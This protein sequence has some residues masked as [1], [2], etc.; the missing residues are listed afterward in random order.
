M[1]CEFVQPLEVIGLGGV[2]GPGFAS[3]I[4]GGREHF[5][6]FFERAFCFPEFD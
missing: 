2:G 4:G 5:V 3:L 1:F 6:H